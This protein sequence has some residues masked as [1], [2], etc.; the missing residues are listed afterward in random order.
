MSVR[1]TVLHKFVLCGY[2]YELIMVGMCSMNARATSARVAA[3]CLLLALHPP[4]S[5]AV[6]AAT[7]TYAAGQANREQHIEEN[8]EGDEDVG[9][10]D[11]A[12]GAAGQVGARQG[13][14]RAAGQ[15]AARDLA[16]GRAE[17][18]WFR[19]AEDIVLG[20]LKTRLY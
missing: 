9:E 19:K 13:G 7:P 8:D 11:A 4:L 14:E 6:P 20:M 3:E 12:I 1:S 15:R 16:R 2:L 10:T 18:K 17:K 5:P